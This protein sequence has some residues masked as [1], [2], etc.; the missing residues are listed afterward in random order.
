[1]S[2]IVHGLLAAL[3]WDRGCSFAA[4]PHSHLRN[5]SFRRAYNGRERPQF[6]RPVTWE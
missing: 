3:C 4:L 5:W 6:F 1:M 2:R